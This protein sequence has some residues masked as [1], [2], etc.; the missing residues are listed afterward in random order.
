MTDD[1]ITRIEPRRFRDESDPRPQVVVIEGE[2]RGQ[3]V[4]VDS[5]LRIGRRP[6]N[7]LVLPSPAVSKYHARITMEGG[8]LSIVD[9]GSTNGSMVNG[10]SLEGHASR[11]LYHG[12]TLVLGDHTL[13]FRNEGTFTDKKTGMSTIAFDMSKV[14]EEVDLLLEGYPDLDT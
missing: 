1:T 8:R 3:V 12:D 13:I 2:A 6:D 10:V 7:Q 9:L 4:M 11:D 5:E 14:R